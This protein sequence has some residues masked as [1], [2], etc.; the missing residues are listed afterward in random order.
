MQLID[1]LRGWDSWLRSGGARRSTLPYT[2]RATPVIL[3][4]VLTTVLLR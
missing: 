1:I 4:V 3:H 2:V